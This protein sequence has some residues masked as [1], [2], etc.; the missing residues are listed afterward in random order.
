L[1]QRRHV[2]GRLSFDLRNEVVVI[3][4][5]V[6][7]ESSHARLSGALARRLEHSACLRRRHEGILIFLINREH[8]SWPSLALSRTLRCW[9]HDFLGSFFLFIVKDAIELRASVSAFLW[10][11]IVVL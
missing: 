10:S 7:K 11:R 2:L 5:V 3:I 6:I 8:C 4:V 1:R 9:L